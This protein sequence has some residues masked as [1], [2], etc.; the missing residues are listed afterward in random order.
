MPNN[1]IDTEPEKPRGAQVVDDDVVSDLIG[2]SERGG[3]GVTRAGWQDADGFGNGLHRIRLHLAAAER[4]EGSPDARPKQTQIVV[5]LRC[6][7]DRGTGSLCRIL[8][9]DRHCRRESVY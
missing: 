3:N 8:L 9:L 6:R 2:H 5:D 1:S 4:T 7:A